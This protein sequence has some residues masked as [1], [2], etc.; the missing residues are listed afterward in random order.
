MTEQVAAVEDQLLAE[1][2]RIRKVVEGIQILLTV[3]FI[4]GFLAAIVLVALVLAG[5]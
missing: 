3:S 2:R 5:Y 4:V 1:T